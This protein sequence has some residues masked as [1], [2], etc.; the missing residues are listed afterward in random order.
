METGLEDV[1]GSAGLKTVGL[2][3]SLC[4]VN[5]LK[6]ARYG[7]QVIGP[8][9]YSFL[10]EV[11]QQTTGANDETGLKAWADEQESPM[12]RYL[13]GVLDH[14]M[15][16]NLLVKSHN[17]VNF[18]LFIAT[19]EKLCPIVFALD[20]VHYSRWLPVFVHELKLL[21]VAEDPDLFEKL[22]KVFLL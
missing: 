12:F 14:I 15:N 13:I 17:E 2:M 10:V 7:G 4:N 1:I 19:L 5:S 11:Y 8:V 6:K 22:H 18:E 21:K 20:H 3:S 9:I 16:V